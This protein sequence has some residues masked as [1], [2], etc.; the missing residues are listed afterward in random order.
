MEI[1]HVHKR[2]GDEIIFQDFSL[3]LPEGEFIAFMGPSGRG[4]TTLFRMI[5]GLEPYEGE[6]IAPKSAA[7]VFQESVFFGSLEFKKKFGIGRCNKENRRV[8]NRA[9]SFGGVG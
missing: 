7:A 4:K 1:I 6:I 5:L 2:F 8:G 9:W 3:H